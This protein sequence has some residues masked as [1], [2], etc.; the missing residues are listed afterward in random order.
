MTPEERDL[1]LRV[2]R[3]NTFYVALSC[4]LMIALA[5]L[6]DGSIIIAGIAPLFCVKH[7]P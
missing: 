6:E 3:T 4:A 1:Y 5:V 2:M 7:L